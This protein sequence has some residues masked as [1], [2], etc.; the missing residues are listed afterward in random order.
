[1][2]VKIAVVTGTGKAL[3]IGRAIARSLISSLN[4]KVVGIDIGNAERL[5]EEDPKFKTQY[6]HYKCDVSSA[7]QVSKIWDSAENAFGT[8]G[9]NGSSLDLACIVNNAAIADPGMPVGDANARILRWK[10]VI[11]VN[12]TGKLTL[13]ENKSIRLPLRLTIN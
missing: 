11:G 10:S 6:I 12:L 7:E 5:D 9:G 8:S 2:S 3:G 13:L 1:M 4:Y